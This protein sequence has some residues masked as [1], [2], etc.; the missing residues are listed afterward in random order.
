MAT[1]VKAAINN[2]QIIQNSSSR[3]LPNTYRLCSS[4]LSVLI[5]FC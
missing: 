3:R 4:P 5:R 2:N 1:N